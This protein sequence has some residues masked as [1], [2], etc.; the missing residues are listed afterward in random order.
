MNQIEVPELIAP[1]W[2]VVANPTF[3]GCVKAIL[4]TLRQEKPE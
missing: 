4:Y 3:N 1:E 2:A